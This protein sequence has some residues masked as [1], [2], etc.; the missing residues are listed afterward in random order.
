MN[1]ELNDKCKELHTIF[2][3]ADDKLNTLRQ[4]RD[5]LIY[6]AYITTEPQKI[7]KNAVSELE[8]SIKAQQALVRDAY[9]AWYQTRSIVFSSLIKHEE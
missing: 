8:L 4:R 3:E 5:T 7:N 2:K 9:E 6:G 1:K